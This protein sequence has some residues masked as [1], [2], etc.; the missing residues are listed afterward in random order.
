MFACPAP[1]STQKCHVR[2]SLLQKK[3]CGLE[4][5]LVASC[6]CCTAL[7]GYMKI[8]RWA[9]KA[10]HA[11]PQC[12]WSVRQFPSRDT[13]KKDR[14]T[15]TKSRQDILTGIS[16]SFLDVPAEEIYKG[17]PSQPLSIDSYK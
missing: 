16:P 17:M 15:G 2:L 8:I 1:L 13:S 14:K 11:K 9:E 12:G 7:Q 6:R 10:K 3:L 5:S 4:F